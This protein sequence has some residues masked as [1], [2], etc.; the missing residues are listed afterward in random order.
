[1]SVTTQR[2]RPA[3]D[4]ARPGSVIRSEF[5]LAIALG[6]AAIF[7]SAGSRLTEI[8]G[9]PVA[10][11]GVF[12]WLFAV[13]LWAAICV[14]RH[15]DCLAIK[16]GEPY[17]TL[18]LTISA[19]SIEVVMISTAMLH[20]ANNP[21]LGRDAIFSVIMIALNGFIGVCLLLG[22]LLYREQHY[23][24]QGVNAYINVILTLAV[25][26][27]VLPNFTTTTS[28]PTFSTK[29]AI[30]FAV[31]SLLLYAIF[32]LIQTMRHRGYF[33]ESKDAPV[34]EN[35]GHGS[36]HVRSTTFHTTMLLLY[37]V[38]VILLAK[39]FAIPLDTASRSL[40]CR[41]SLVAQ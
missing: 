27:L 30:F 10:L 4:A 17:G 3:T 16:L 14:A 22:G 25:L 36:L 13:I 5:A 39:K 18:I 28:G 32:L 33:L 34:V 6:T 29:Q 1:M 7:F 38:S 31:V 21:E 26:G 20:G 15:A 37:L 23:N 41:R 9:H 11:T 19:I 8:I 2:N 35:S 12:L 40:V 24:L